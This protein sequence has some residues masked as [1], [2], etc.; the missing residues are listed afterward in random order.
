VGEDK[1]EL[2]DHQKVSCNQTSGLGRSISYTSFNKPSSITRQGAWN[3]LPI[4]RRCHYPGSLH[5]QPNRKME[6]WT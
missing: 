1:N 5:S 2:I 4:S 3:A 6:P